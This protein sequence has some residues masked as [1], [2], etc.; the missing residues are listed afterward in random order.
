[1]NHDSIMHQVQ[2][3]SRDSYRKGI[4]ISHLFAPDQG[5]LYKNCA[6]INEMWRWPIASLQGAETKRQY[7]SKV[8][9]SGNALDSATPDDLLTSQLV[10]QS[11]S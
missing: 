3:L 8:H 11:Q 9:Y 7:P 6:M 1:M 2:S 10:E 4:H 5:D